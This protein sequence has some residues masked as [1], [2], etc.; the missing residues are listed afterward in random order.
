MILDILLEGVVGVGRNVV[1]K[2]VLV[3]LMALGACWETTHAEGL[4]FMIMIDASSQNLCI[5]SVTVA[6]VVLYVMDLGDLYG[7]GYAGC[8]ACAVDMV[9][10]TLHLEHDAPSLLRESTCF[11]ST[12]LNAWVPSC[13]YSL[14]S[15]LLFSSLFPSF[16]EIHRTLMPLSLGSEEISWLINCS[17]IL[18]KRRLNRSSHSSVAGKLD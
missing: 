2:A 3:V 16:L 4:L 1:P 17:V 15:T 11:T 9:Y 12:I 14:A 8:L 10:F 5:A 6:L 7:C 18:T 13:T